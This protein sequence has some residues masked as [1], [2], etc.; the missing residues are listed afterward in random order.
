MMKQFKRVGIL[1][2]MGPQAT[3]L[4]Q[5]RVLDSVKA[6]DDASHLPLLVDM[7]PQVPSRLDWILRQQGEDPAPVLASMAKGLETAGAQAL[8]MPCNTAHHFA[9]AITNAVSIPF[10]NMLDMATS[11]INHACTTGDKVGMLASTATIDIQLFENA[12]APHQ[13]ETLWPKDLS[14]MLT[15]IRNI[16]A[17]QAAAT[18]CENNGATCLVVGCTEFSLLSKELESNLPIIDTLDLLVNRIHHF[19]TS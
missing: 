8:A 13:L 2:G 3:L 7:N 5:Q 12:L 9:D 17:M 1:G 15:T 16:K 18:E 11:A 6:S 19:A 4:L 10:L 14:A